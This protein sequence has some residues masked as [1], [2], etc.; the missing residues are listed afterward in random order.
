MS[1]SQVV[2][3]DVVKASHP[4]HHWPTTLV[5]LLLQWKEE[6]EMFE[7]RFNS[8][9]KELHDV[10]YA[11]LAIGCWVNSEEQNNSPSFNALNRG[12]LHPLRESLNAET[13][14][15]FDTYIF[16]QFQESME[17]ENEKDVRDL[18]TMAARHVAEVKDFAPRAV[19]KYFRDCEYA[20]MKFIDYRV[21]PLVK[22]TKVFNPEDFLE[23][24]WGKVKVSA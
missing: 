23:T 4:L 16:A 7:L 6:M 14:V 11:Q 17:A 19:A 8:V 12:F 13:E 2:L 24:R 21:T 10:Y 5:V 18:I 15:L 3:L 1:Y 22:W 20:K 9:L